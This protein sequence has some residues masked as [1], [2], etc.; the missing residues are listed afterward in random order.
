MLALFE[1][2]LD[3]KYNGK[4]IF[5]NLLLRLSLYSEAVLIGLSDEPHPKTVK[6]SS[7]H[8]TVL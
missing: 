6:N 7:S 5:L 4:K 1:G 3:L 2:N 8:H